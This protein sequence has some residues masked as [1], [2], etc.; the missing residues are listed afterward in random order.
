MKCVQCIFQ[1]KYVCEYAVLYMCIYGC[2]HLAFLF[3][4]CNCDCVKQAKQ[5]QHRAHC[6]CL[7]SLFFSDL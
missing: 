2:M 5:I 7:R 4:R 3:V 1:S 6:Q